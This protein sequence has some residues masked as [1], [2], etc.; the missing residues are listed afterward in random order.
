MTNLNCNTWITFNFHHQPIEERILI[1][2]FLGNYR[3]TEEDSSGDWNDE[4]YESYDDDEHTDMALGGSGDGPEITPRKL[5]SGDVKIVHDN[6]NVSETEASTTA[7]GVQFK[8]IQLDP[9]IATVLTTE[10]DLQIG[11]C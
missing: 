1:F 3:C 11:E 6:L 10:H 4:D 9:T 2:L 8:L 7:T 5:D